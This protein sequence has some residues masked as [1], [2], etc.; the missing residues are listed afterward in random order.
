MQ[1]CHH[2]GFCIENVTQYPAVYK[3]T[4][5]AT[6]RLSTVREHL[7][8]KCAPRRRTYNSQQQQ[9]R[10][11]YSLQSQLNTPTFRD[12]LS[13]ALAD[14]G[15]CGPQTACA[16]ADAAI[17]RSCETDDRCCGVTS[18]GYIPACF[19]THT[20][21]KCSH[22]HV[23]SI[24][25]TRYRSCSHVGLDQNDSNSTSGSIVNICERCRRLLRERNDSHSYL[26]PN[27]QW[28]HLNSRTFVVYDHPWEATE[29]YAQ[30]HKEE[31]TAYPKCSS[32]SANS[33]HLFSP[34]SLV[35][36]RYPSALIHRRELESFKVLTNCIVE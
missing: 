21:V 34:T 12:Y 23:E 18:N 28:N 25:C 4:R 24:M 7:Y 2:F 9:S 35:I 26:A 29:E 3:S 36:L 30:V 14:T 22:C 31:S 15:V 5:L 16:V 10:S 33:P 11:T 6:G 27:A 13:S 8:S 17:A 32:T 20:G 19:S 1:P